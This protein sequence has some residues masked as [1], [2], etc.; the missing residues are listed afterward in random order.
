MRH[1]IREPSVSRTDR[2]CATT[3]P[4]PTLYPR[5]AQ[6]AG[7]PHVD[8][9]GDPPAPV[10]Q[11]RAAAAIWSLRCA[12]GRRLPPR[13]QSTRNFL[14][15]PLSPAL[16]RGSG[17]RAR[18]SRSAPAQRPPDRA[19]L[20]VRAVA[21]RSRA[22]PAA[23]AGDRSRS[24]PSTAHG[25]RLRDLFADRVAA[26]RERHV[27]HCGALV[28]ADI[29]VDRRASAPIRAGSSPP[30]SASRPRRA[31][32][33]R[34]MFVSPATAAAT[35]ARRAS[36]FHAAQHLAGERG[37]AGR[38]LRLARDPA[39]MPCDSTSAG[40]R[41]APRCESLSPNALSS[42]RRSARACYAGRT[43]W[44]GL[45]PSGEMPRALS[46]SSPRGRDPRASYS[47]CIGIGA[48]RRAVPFNVAATTTAGIEKDESSSGATSESLRASTAA[49]RRARPSRVSRSGRSTSSIRPSQLTFAAPGR[50]PDGEATRTSAIFARQRHLIHRRGLAR[51][52]RPRRSFVALRVRSTGRAVRRDE[53]RRQVH[54]VVDL[55]TPPFW[56]ATTMMRIIDS[57]SDRGHD[58][59]VARRAEFPAPRA[60]ASRRRDLRESLFV[61]AVSPFSSRRA[62]LSAQCWPQAAAARR[63]S[64]CARDDDVEQRVG[65]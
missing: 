24:G 64:R 11:A 26:A 38:R 6:H 8:A 15:Q 36:R 57:P 42:R 34:I 28:F 65:T 25:V 54:P 20:T 63:G 29:S 3:P 58:D 56:F 5:P 14:D 47:R 62:G 32:F 37:Y 1:A 41:P 59:E 44:Q 52:S 16:P 17:P 51:L 49:P 60:L 22:R 4:Q 55:P 61:V 48:M 35:S 9:R 19:R 18:C 30:Q 2:P 7:V 43:S 10:A 40:E 12:S 53:R 45:D 13:R 33:G 50:S 39:R 27:V 23:L 31:L 46:S 21:A